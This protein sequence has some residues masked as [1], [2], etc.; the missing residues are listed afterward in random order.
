MLLLGAHGV[1]Y[2]SILLS[3]SPQQPAHLG[4]PVLEQI[5]RQISYQVSW[6]RTFGGVE[7]DKGESLIEVSTT[8][9]GDGFVITGVTESYGTGDYDLWLSRTN[10]TGHQVWNQLFG[11][12][13]H[14]YGYSVIECSG[15]GLA[16]AGYTSSYGA[17]PGVNADAW[18]VRTDAN[19]NHLWNQTYGG[20]GSEYGYCVVEC[21]GGGFA[22][23]GVQKS[24]G[25]GYF[26]LWLVRTDAY[27]VH[28]WNSSFGGPYI[29]DGY[30]LVECSD[31]GFAIAGRYSTG[32]DMD[33]L[34]V[35][36]DSNGD[37]LWNQTYGGPGY[38]MCW[39]IIA[40]STGGFI[41]V[42]N[43]AS[44]GA[45]LS[46]MWVVRVGAG[47]N[48]LWN[49]TYGTTNNDGAMDIVEQA[50]G[51]FAVVGHYGGDLALVLIDS[52]GSVQS[53][54]TYGGGEYE[55]GFALVESVLGGFTI[56][57]TTMS[58]GAGGEDIWLVRIQEPVTATTLPPPIPGF[59]LNAIALG[60]AATIGLGVVFR[61]HQ[62]N[63]KRTVSRP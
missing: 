32:S 37:Q 62:R 22:I 46:D 44:Y 43:T 4:N 54:L 9:S 45:G 47:G 8:T 38:E 57:G 15:G 35:R 5:S 51:G 40:P 61:R 48:L 60:V 1:A 28:L 42:G 10:T 6:N 63:L 53:I 19:G 20:M 52:T 58:F 30:S 36:T 55:E 21:S 18:L 11:G 50:T 17:N 41:L 2:S 39:S 13:S 34:L 3:P 29:D 59:P 23:A 33:F 31:G 16:I 49:Y 12:S 25:L 27:G 7:Q 56:V 24:G 14:D 26:E